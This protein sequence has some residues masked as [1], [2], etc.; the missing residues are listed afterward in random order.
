ME[1]RIVSLSL[2]QLRRSY[3]LARGFGEL[4]LLSKRKREPKDG[5]LLL[6]KDRARQYTVLE[7]NSSDKKISL[8]GAFIMTRSVS[9]TVSRK[10]QNMA[11]AGV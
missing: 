1:K 6:C 11:N 2:L 9:K 7:E 8:G 4:C 5:L 10:C 3:F